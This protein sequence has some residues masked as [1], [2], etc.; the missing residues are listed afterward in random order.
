MNHYRF[1]V[2]SPELFPDPDGVWMA[3]PAD[4][5]AEARRLSLCLIRDYPE[6]FQ[7]DRPWVMH[8]LD[9]ETLVAEFDMRQALDRP[10][11]FAWL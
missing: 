1:V 7:S 6:V 3:N 11:R 5:A 4:V 9:G 10:P 2:V 8:V